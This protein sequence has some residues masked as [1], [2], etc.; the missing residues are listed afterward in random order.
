M[1]I[2]RS[3]VAFGPAAGVLV[4]QKA[5][6]VFA[7]HAQRRPGS[8]EMSEGAAG[9]A[10]AREAWSGWFPAARTSPVGYALVARPVMIGS[11]G[12]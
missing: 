1:L 8:R 10:R 12:W 6:N 11:T 5:V 3:A 7:Q 9:T 2:S 4:L